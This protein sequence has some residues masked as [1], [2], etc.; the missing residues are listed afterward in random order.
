MVYLTKLLLAYSCG[1]IDRYRGNSINV[2]YSKTVEAVIYGLLVGSIF[3]T[4]L[5]LVLPFAVL[6][7]LG[8]SFGWGEPLGALLTG[9]EMNPAKYE[10]WQFW[11]LKKSPMFAC[12]FRGVMWGAC[13][14]PIA[15]FDMKASAFVFVM[16]M[17]FPLAVRLAS[18]FIIV[19]ESNW[20]RQE[21]YRGWLAGLAA[22]V[23]SYS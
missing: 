23:L 15:Y 2:F 17:I 13:V 5:R 4:D 12:I 6:W 11:I 3:L 22:L 19:N 7:A 9:R 8:A 10:W 1:L 21:Y 20:A 14:L 18:K 16:G